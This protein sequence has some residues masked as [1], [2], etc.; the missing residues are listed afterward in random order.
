MCPLFTGTTQRIT[1]L[2]PLRIE[3]VTTILL[4]WQEVSQSVTTHCTYKVGI[5]AL[6]IH[7]AIM[8][9][10]LLTM[11][12][13]QQL[14]NQQYCSINV[15]ACD[16]NFNNQHYNWENIG[17]VHWE[18]RT[19]WFQINYPKHHSLILNLRLS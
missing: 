16:Y 11:M 19:N 10:T 5:Q 2:T 7:L 4:N 9:A 3:N 17:Y 14:I 6:S 13:L 15:P 18:F 8:C 1:W 12:Y